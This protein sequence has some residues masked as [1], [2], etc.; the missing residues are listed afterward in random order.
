[1]SMQLTFGDYNILERLEA[2]EPIRHFEDTLWTMFEAGLIVHE[3][4]ILKITQTGKQYLS[5]NKKPAFPKS[6]H[7]D[8]EPI[9]CTVCKTNPTLP[10]C[11]GCRV[12]IEAS[13]TN[14]DDQNWYINQCVGKIKYP[15]QDSAENASKAM[16]EKKQKEGSG[17]TFDVYE[18]P[19]CSMPDSEGWHIGG[20]YVSAVAQ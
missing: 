2:G 5:S 10:T 8:R 20:K 15:R 11:A 6:R 17:K 4:S 9:V 3:T 12:R 19:W 7:H 18:C 14:P 16:V 1:M 13:G